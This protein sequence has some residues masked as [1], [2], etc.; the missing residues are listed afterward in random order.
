MKCSL[1]KWTGINHDPNEI[2]HKFT[3]WTNGICVNAALL[4]FEM[5]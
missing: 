2:V 1:S 4:Y 3:S 5:L